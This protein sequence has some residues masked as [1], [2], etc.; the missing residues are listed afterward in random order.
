MTPKATT[1]SVDTAFGALTG[2]ARDMN[3][4][5]MSLSHI[6]RAVPV[7]RHAHRYVAVER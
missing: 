1:A 5:G 7:C 2:C 3:A 6:A 4:A